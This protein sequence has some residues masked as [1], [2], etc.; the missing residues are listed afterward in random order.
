MLGTEVKPARTC[1]P[2]ASQFK[3]TA[4][5]AMGVGTLTKNSCCRIGGNGPKKH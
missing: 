5:K 1:Q 4:L 2:F 3:P